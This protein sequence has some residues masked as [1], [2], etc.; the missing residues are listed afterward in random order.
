M[1]SKSVVG[2]VMYGEAKEDKNVWKDW[3]AYAKSVSEMLDYKLTHFGIESDS[4]KDGNVKT[5]SRSG[6]RL[7]EII[8][9]YENIEHLSF[10]SLPKNYHTACG[11]NELYIDLN[12]R[13][14]YVYCEFP[15]EKY[16]ESLGERL[17]NDMGNFII[18][19]KSEIFTMEK[20]RGAINYVFKGMG[21]DISKYP[22]LEILMQNVY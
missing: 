10:Y 13:R 14:K 16:N 9:N 17:L 6:K 8:H 4:W 7:L 1:G 5:L 19:N 20:S 3:L 11:S 21:D 18:C 2:I 22:T 12:A 15:L